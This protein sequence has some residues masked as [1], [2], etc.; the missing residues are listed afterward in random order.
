MKAAVPAESYVI[1]LTSSSW[2]SCDVYGQ[3][4]G[5]CRTL[6]FLIYFLSFYLSRFYFIR[7]Q[8]KN[9]NQNRDSNLGPPVL[10]VLLGQSYKVDMLE[11][12]LFHIL[13]ILVC[14]VW[15]AIVFVIV[16]LNGTLILP[17][18]SNQSILFVIESVCNTVHHLLELWGVFLKTIIYIFNPRS[19]VAVVSYRD[20]SAVSSRFRMLN[21][22]GK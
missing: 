10:L 6:S 9:L 16:H 17:F 1:H 8:E 12:A 18:K 21:F 7:S 15:F 3:Q 5:R 14:V 13:I 11:V 20:R 22:L 4:P 19:T 2:V